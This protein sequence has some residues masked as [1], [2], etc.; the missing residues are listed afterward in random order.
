MEEPI[1]PFI[2]AQ[3][4]AFVSHGIDRAHGRR[5]DA[6][7][8]ADSLVS[9][10]TQYV[11][12]WQDQVLVQNQCLVPSDA[13]RQDA[14][15]HLQRFN[16]VEIV[17]VRRQCPDE[18]VDVVL[19][20]LLGHTTYYALGI[21]DGCEAASRGAFEGG[22][23]LDLRSAAMG[24]SREEGA[25]AAQAKA[26]VH[27]HLQHRFCGRCGSPMQS[28]EGG[29]LRRC[30]NAACGQVHFPRVDPAI[31]VLVTAGE[32]CLLGRQPRWPKG[33]YSNV[34]GFVEPGESLETA[35][36]REVYEET[37]IAIRGVEY[38]SSQPWPFPQSLMVGFTAEAASEEIH[39]NDGELEDARWFTRSSIRTEL[40]EGVLSLPSPY[41]V[42][43]HLIEDWYD[44]G[45]GG[46]LSELVVGTLG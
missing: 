38:H 22:Q 1:D 23:F 28:E 19:L 43:F 4:N 41:S 29:Y 24:L 20:G 8:L 5:L 11:V 18:L 3:N 37:G 44:L 36:A 9:P 12:V 46:K 39:L 27:W 32:R 13:P 35:I 26:M 21:D 7:W 30:A 42:S 10:E 2:R 34:A 15:L 45:E 33:R 25:L 40:L 6:S 31:I 14:L 16:G 17:E